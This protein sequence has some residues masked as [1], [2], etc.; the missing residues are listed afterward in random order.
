MSLCLSVCLYDLYVYP[1]SQCPY[2]MPQN[3]KNSMGDPK[4]RPSYNKWYPPK[5]AGD[6]QWVVGLG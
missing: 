3:A 6:T 1:R 5:R 2:Q 4:F